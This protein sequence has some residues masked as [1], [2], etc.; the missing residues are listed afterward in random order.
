VTVKL[1]VLIIIP[2]GGK[3]VPDELTGN[4]IL[5]PEDI[6]FESD[7]GA[8]R[9]F[10]SP[11]TVAEPVSTVISKLFVDPD[12]E[13]TALSPVTVDG[14]IKTRTSMNREV[15]RQKCYPDEIAISN[16]L[17]RYYFP[18]H[19]SIRGAIRSGGIRLIL[20]CHT[21]AAVG[22]VN[23]PDAGRPRPLVITKYTADSDSGVKK[24]AA[25]DLAM[26]LASITGRMIQREGETVSEKYSVA[27]HD[28]RGCLMHRYAAAAPMLVLSVSRALFLND[29]H[30]H[31][32]SLTIDSA[33]LDRIGGL[34][35]SG[36]EKFCDRFF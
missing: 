18:F 11:M 14:V 13:F 20:E 8:N 5:S 27:I 29:R 7:A 25:P 9:I 34:I 4:E 17:E 15:F 21:H 31:M 22:P 36:I 1:P 19:E 2:H 24:T 30:F 12:R 3:E 23:A 16:I 26:E 10:Y 6:F 32:E 35:F 33:R 28:T